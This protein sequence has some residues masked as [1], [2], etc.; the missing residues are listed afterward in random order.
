MSPHL[1]FL[2]K[3]QRNYGPTSNEVTEI[4]MKLL[5]I[6]SQK[7]RNFKTFYRT[8]RNFLYYYRNFEK[9]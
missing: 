5:E 3:L 8:W 4:L 1:I 9:K 7:M 2:M 6:N